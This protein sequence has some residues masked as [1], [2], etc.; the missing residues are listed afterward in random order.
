MGRADGRPLSVS[1]SKSCRRICMFGWSKKFEGSDIRATFEARREQVRRHVLGAGRAV[2]SRFQATGAAT[3]A[4]LRAASAVVLDGARA[5]R[6]VAAS[7]SR[8][9][10]DG[11]TAAASGAGLR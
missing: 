8:R 1:V 11:V 5:G 10:L 4:G 7:G 3:A 9:A 6:R 2:G